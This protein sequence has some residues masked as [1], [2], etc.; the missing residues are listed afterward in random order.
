MFEKNN[1]VLLAN[2]QQPLDPLKHANKSICLCDRLRRRQMGAR[3][4]RVFLACPAPQ[5]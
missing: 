2:Q 5:A 1:K 3:S 4:F